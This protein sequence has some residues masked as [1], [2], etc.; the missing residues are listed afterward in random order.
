MN[1]MEKRLL[2]QAS[3]GLME[4][5]EAVTNT[6]TMATKYLISSF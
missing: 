3:K 5:S 1:N 4:F 6:R 2:E